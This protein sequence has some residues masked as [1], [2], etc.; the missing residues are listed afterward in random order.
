MDTNPIFYWQ[1]MDMYYAGSPWMLGFE[2]FEFEHVQDNEELFYM[3]FY[4]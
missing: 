3:Y 4:F 2:T 1:P